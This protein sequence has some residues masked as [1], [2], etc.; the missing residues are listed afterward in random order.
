MLVFIVIFAGSNKIFMSQDPKHNPS[1]SDDIDLLLLIERSLAFFRRYILIFIIAIVAGLAGGIY[2]YNYLPK[3]Y[4]SSM[5]VHSFVLTNQENIKI[6][7]NWNDLLKKREYAELSATLNSPE[8]VFRQ[9]K[10][11]QAEEIQK[12]FSTTNPNGFVVKVTVTDNAIL[13]ELQKAIVYGLENS[14]YVKGRLD[15][16]KENLKVI[17]AKTSSEIQKLDSTKNTVENIIEGKGKSSS[18]LIVEGAT[19]NK[20][21]IELNEKLLGYQDDLKFAAAVQV[22]QGFSKFSEPA[23]PHLLPW[24]FIGLVIFLTLG[25]LLAFLVHMSGKMRRRRLVQGV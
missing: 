4:R 25:F 22:Y 24:L 17:I 19:I 8:S 21:M 2:M 1:V 20:Q 11:I 7:D 5:V 9:T 3:V 6:L 15:S 10:N 16:R 12:V 13:D 14:P 18:T 23:G